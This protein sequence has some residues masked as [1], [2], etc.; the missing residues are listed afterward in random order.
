MCDDDGMA[1]GKP[2]LD[3]FLEA[4]CML[5]CTVSPN[6][7]DGTAGVREA[8]CAERV[9][10][11]VFEDMVPGMEAGKHARINGVLS[12]PLCV[13]SY[14]SAVAY[15]IDGPANGENLP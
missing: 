6:K 9:V 5:G 2:F 13:T 11:L 8:K 10:G 4:A 15:I 14:G 12:V 3:I 7:D 1:H